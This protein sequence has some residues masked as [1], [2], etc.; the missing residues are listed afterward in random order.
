MGELSIGTRVQTS[1]QLEALMKRWTW[2][3]AAILLAM[4][5]FAVASPALA[6][7]DKPKIDI[8]FCIDCS[9]SMGPVIETAKQKVWAIVNEVARAKPSP[10]LRIGIIGYGNAMGPFRQYPLSSDLDEV[11][12]NL[13]PFDDRLGGDE[14]VGLAIHKA[15]TEMKW[16]EGKQVM[17]IIYVVGNETAHQGPAE[18]DYTKT[19]PAAIAKGIMVN[20]IYCGDYDY[21]IAHGTWQEI[22]KLADG[23]YMEIAG[24]GGAVTVAT[25]FDQQLADLSGKLNTTYVGYGGQREAKAA[26]Q[27]ANDASSVRFNLS[28]AADRAGAKASRQYDNATWDLVDAARNK[29]FDIRKIK[30]EDLPE[31]M[32]KMTPDERAAFV[33]K[34]AKERE[35]IATQVKELSTKRD[36]YIKAEIEKKGLDTN[37]A[38]DEAVK[39]SIKEEGA[40]K[41]FEF[42]GKNGAEK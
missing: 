9:G 11:Y 38:F 3:C 37:K 1:V 15:T 32:R 24:K 20:T 42:E 18:F 17:K 6:A 8:V 30:T 19:A 2:V 40:K 27:A 5:F 29:D 7:E 25:P 33:E 31:E 23:A 10:E 22:A 13:L 36:A 41:G 14:Y 21:A 4:G 34:K 39:K 28:S 12:K 16:A 26:A 35:E